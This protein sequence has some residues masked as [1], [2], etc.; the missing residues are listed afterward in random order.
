[1]VNMFF[2]FEK[3]WF[4][5][6]CIS[7]YLY[8]QL[9]PIKNMKKE[10]SD[11]TA[12]LSFFFSIPCKTNTIKSDQCKPGASRSSAGPHIN[13][14]RANNKLKSATNGGSDA[15][16]CN[17]GDEILTGRNAAFCDS[18]LALASVHRLEQ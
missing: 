4:Y 9:H 11:T 8:L 3:N 7:N 18:L 15:K 13:F 2:Y 10:F 1:M 6:S 14:S 12:L 5:I 17:K 16:A